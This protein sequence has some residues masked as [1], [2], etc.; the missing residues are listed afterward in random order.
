L[1]AA[2]DFF[3]ADSF[4]VSAHAY[5]VLDRCSRFGALC[6]AAASLFSLGAV[7]P[8]G[9]LRSVGPIL[10]CCGSPRWVSRTRSDFHFGAVCAPVRSLISVTRTKCSATKPAAIS[11]AMTVSSLLVSFRLAFFDSDFSN[12]V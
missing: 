1:S 6:S 12:W 2:T 4:F 9:I 8:R 3:C 10:L 7:F 11:R 5:Q